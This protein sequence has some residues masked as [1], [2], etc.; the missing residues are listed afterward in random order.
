[1]TFPFHAKT[2]FEQK[3]VFIIFYTNGNFKATF[4]KLGNTMRYN[5]FQYNKLLKLIYLRR[6]FYTAIQ[7]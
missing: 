1:M 3:N 2:K 5:G 7:F 4:G 6:N